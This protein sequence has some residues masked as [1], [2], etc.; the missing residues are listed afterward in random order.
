MV[1]SMR[2]IREPSVNVDFE[3][4]ESMIRFTIGNSGQ[5]SAKNITFQVIEDLPWLTF[6]E[7][8]GISSI[9]IIKSGISYLTPGRTLKFIAG[10]IHGE[11][12]AENNVLKIL[13]RYE[14]DMGRQFSKEIVIDMSQYRSL[15]FESFKDSNLSVAEA[16]RETERNR[17]S[18]DYADNFFKRPKKECPVCAEFIP[19]RAKKCA[20]CGAEIPSAEERLKKPNGART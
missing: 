11:I 7:Q 2:E 9:P 20:H 4:P 1:D 17:N 8:T 19:V 5:S 13:I 12:P 10:Y 3:L 14:N 18:E 15:L 16:I 6:S